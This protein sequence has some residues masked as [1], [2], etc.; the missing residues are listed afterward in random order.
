MAE[1]FCAISG[2]D[3]LGK[4]KSTNLPGD[5]RP[6]GQNAAFPRATVEG[7]VRRILQAQAGKLKEVDANLETV[8]FSDWRKCVAASLALI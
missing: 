2:I 7:E 5:K 8:L 4:K 1:T 3:P 6:K